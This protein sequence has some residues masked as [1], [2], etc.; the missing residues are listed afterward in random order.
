ML[1]YSATLK[2]KVLKMTA[3][4]FAHDCVDG[5]SRIYVNNEA[6]DYV[7]TVNSRREA[8]RIINC[9][10]ACRGMPDELLGPDAFIEVSAQLTAVA[11][12]RDS[13]KKQLKAMEKELFDLNIERDLIHAALDD[14][15]K[16]LN[17][18]AVQSGTAEY[19]KT[20]PEIIA[21]ARCRATL[22]TTMH[23]M[24]DRN[25]DSSNE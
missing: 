13:L 2:K 25:K 24:F 21:Y 23:S 9:V 19:M 18:V 10:D 16:S 7:A 12:E 1:F 22:A 4:L 6:F 20:V 14:A 11:T 5:K 17:T 8:T 15:A 3:N